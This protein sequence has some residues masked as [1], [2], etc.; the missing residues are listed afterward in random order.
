MVYYAAKVLISAALVVLVSELAKRSTLAGAVLAS[1]PLVSVL[2]MIWLYA[3]THDA[4]QVGALSRSIFW[5]VLPSLVLFVLLPV[6][7]QRGYG[8]YASLAASIG[9]TVVA[10][11][12]MIAAAR[13]FGLRL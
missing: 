2:A 1:I 7:L 9:A 11:F 13:H 3:G 6:L 5:L 10:Y 12:G 8:F 4:A